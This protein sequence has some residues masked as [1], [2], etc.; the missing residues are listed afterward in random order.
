MGTETLYF[1]IVEI[2]AFYRV[3]PAMATGGVDRAVFAPYHKIVNVT[4]RKRHGGDSH[5][6]ALFEHQ[7]QTVLQGKCKKS[8]TKQLIF[9]SVFIVAAK[10]VIDVMSACLYMRPYISCTCGWESMSRLQEHILPSVEMLIRL[11]A[12]WVPTTFTQ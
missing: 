5:R 11:L 9:T 1:I 3:L 8:Q 12:F 2:Q 7:L 6:F 4:Q 10:K